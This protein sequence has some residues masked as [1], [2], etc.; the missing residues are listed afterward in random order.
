MFYKT[1]LFIDQYPGLSG[2]QKVLFTIIADFVK[3]GYHCLAILPEKGELSQNL[4][5]LKVDSIFFPIGY[6]SITQK[7][8]FDLLNYAVR[9]PILIFLLTRLIIKKRPGLVYANGARTY[10]WATLACFFTKTQLV[11]HLHS[12]FNK[13]MMKQLCIIF[14]GFPVVNKI[15]AVSIAAA[16]PL[17]KLGPKIKIIYNG[18]SLKHDSPK[19]NTF[20]DEFNIPAGSFLVGNIGILED[21][22][23]QEDLIQAANIIKNK[24]K[25]NIYFF[26]IGDSL[27]PEPSRQKYKKHLL[28]LTGELGLKEKVFFLGF[29]SNAQEIMKGLDLMVICSKDPDP[30]PLVS[31]E[32]A[33]IGL[34]ILAADL[35]G[36]KE[37]FIPDNEALFYPPLKYQILAEKIIAASENNPD[38]KAISKAA[39]DKVQKEYTI[40]QF[41]NKIHSSLN[42]LLNNNE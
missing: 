8:I 33:S 18:V 16:E 42:R 23:N 37:M 5:E 29:R 22:K 1:I 9:L 3:K 32:A 40:D 4:A 19:N 15:I 41:L 39:L 7:T 27:Y 31:L 30:C 24:G 25:T 26:M 21:W 11:W 36:V 17:A 28:K 34:P 2:G 38:L 35:G 20:K 10:F 13:G 12:I 14:G 6:Y